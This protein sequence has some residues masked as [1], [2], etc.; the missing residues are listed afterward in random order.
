MVKRLLIL[1][2]L[3]SL[4]WSQAHAV[5]L[6]TDNNGAIDVELGGTNALTDVGARSNLG[7]TAITDPLVT[8]TGVSS[9]SQSMGAFTGSTIPDNQTIKSAIQYL[10]ASVESIPGDVTGVLDDTGGTVP[11][12]MQAATAF[13]STDATPSV[14]GHSVFITANASATTITDFDDATNGQIIWVIVN[15]AN[16]TFDFTS[17]GL[18]GTS[19]DYTAANGEVLGFIYS[20][21]DSQWHFFGFPK[22]L[23]N[24]TV[25]GGTENRGAVWNSSGNLISK[26]GSE[27]I[28]ELCIENPSTSHVD[29]KKKIPANATITGVY[30][31]C[32]GGTNVVG[33]LYE[34]DADADD[35]DKA[36]ID[37]SDWTITTS[38][39]TDESL[40]NGAVDA[41]DW[42]QWDT[43]SVSGSVTMFC[44][45]AWGYWQ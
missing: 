15:D 40:T 11:V 25:G 36:G 12:L 45:T 8:L 5:E 9:G 38:Q 2:A 21:V 1:L 28:F 34:V 31:H 32:V 19:A 43:T 44:V 4:S 14:S 26:S 20:A 3:V 7:I 35:S 10:E 22:T 23:V 41:G 37:S 18:E 33:R 24:V 39:F 27:V 30:G 6:D 16:T 42:L 29:I 17:S 13:S